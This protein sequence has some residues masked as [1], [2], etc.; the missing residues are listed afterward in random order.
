MLGPEGTAAPGGDGGDLEALLGTLPIPIAV[1]ETG[2]GAAVRFVNTTFTRVFGYSLADLPTLDAWARRTFPDPAQRDAVMARWT[3]EVAARKA[4]GRIAPPGEFRI[5]DKAGRP[6]DVLVG[7]ALQGDLVIVTFQDLTDTRAAEAALEAERRANERTA[8]ALTENMPAGAYTMVLRPGAALAEF[9]FV[10]RQFLRMLDLTRAEATGAPMAVFSRVHPDDRARWVRAHTEA[11]ARCAPFS[12]E[13]RIV[14]NGET[15][16][17]RAEAVPRVRD[18][19]SVIWEGVLVDI[20]PLK[21]AE[22][23]LTSVLEAARAYSWRRDLIRR[24]SGFDARWGVLAGHPPDMRSMPS[25]AWPRTVHPADLPQV[26]AALDAL[27]RGAVENHVL[28]YRRRVRDGEW[29]WLRVHAG[30]SDRD[31]DGRPV[32]LSGVSFDITDEMTARAHAEAERARLREELQRAQQRDIVAQIAGGVAHDL[33]NLIAVVAG[34]AEMLALRADDLPWLHKGLARIRRSVGMADDL[35]AGLGGLVRPDLPRGTHDLGQMLRNAV[36]LLG[37]QRIGRHG[38][39]VT[40]GAPLPQVWANPT[41]LAQ[42]IVNLAINAC[43]SGPPGRPATV[44][45]AAQPVG[46]APPTRPPD[47]GEPPPEGQ[48]MALFTISDTG[49]GLTEAVRARMFRPNFTTKGQHGTGMGLLIVSTILKGNGAAIWADST[50]GAGTTMTVAW[51]AVAP[52][53]ARAG[54]GGCGVAVLPG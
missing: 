18:D 46:T 39:R 45:I 17:V 21:R 51:P 53:R 42:V 49:T 7:F 6:R 47:A 40:L 41:E 25:D 48:P 54:Q 36:D 34:T 12:D 28:T 5:L 8:H 2:D 44:T 10:S 16:W 13:T 19:G 30:I 50:P 27:E 15:R 23:E 4:T 32:A 52:A 35:I 24:Q 11:F 1:H 31:A 20:D 43:D 9:A 29:I 22:R 33:K 38:V 37:Q 3:A 14:A 26:Q